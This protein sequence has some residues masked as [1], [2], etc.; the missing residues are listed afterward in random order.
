MTTV[1]TYVTGG[2]LIDPKII[3]MANKGNLTLVVTWAPDGGVD[4]AVQ[5]KFRLAKIMAGKYDISLRALGT[6]LKAL[7]KPAIFR[8][9]PE[10]NTPWHAWSGLVNG[11]KPAPVRQGLPPRPHG[12]QGHRQGQGAGPLGART[13]AACRSRPR[14]RSRTTSRARS[15]ST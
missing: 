10:P 8:P 2:T 5:P 9:M 1:A 3:Q 14:T 7:K 6:Q 12:R 15:S 13:P 11:N 4:K